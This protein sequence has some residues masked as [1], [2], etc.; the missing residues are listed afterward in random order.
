MD[1]KFIEKA[2]VELREDE[3]RKRQSLAQFRDWLS[4]HPFLK[5]VRQGDF[6]CS[7]PNNIQIARRRNCKVTPLANNILI[8]DS[9]RPSRVFVSYFR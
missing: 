8:S 4:K 3:L 7:S 5:D 1:S 9:R 6:L 2:R